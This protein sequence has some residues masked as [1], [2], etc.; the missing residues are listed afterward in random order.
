V[1]VLDE[2]RVAAGA[3]VDHGVV[4][5][6]AVPGYAELTGAGR[7]YGCGGVGRTVDCT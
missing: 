3:V 1:E 6:W 2:L 5:L 7:A 4:V